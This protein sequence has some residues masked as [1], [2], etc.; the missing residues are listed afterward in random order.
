MQNTSLMRYRVLFDIA[1]DS[2]FGRLNRFGGGAPGVRVGT[3]EDDEKR[4]QA[5]GDEEFQK[6]RREALE[7]IDRLRAQGIECELAED[8]SVVRKQPPG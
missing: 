6:K 2:F 5:N 4:R 7:L 1:T 3:N 8:L